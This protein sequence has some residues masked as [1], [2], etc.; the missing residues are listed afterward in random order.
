MLRRIPLRL[1]RKLVLRTPRLPVAERQCRDESQRA[2]DNGKQH[3]A[4]H[5]VIALQMQWDNAGALRRDPMKIFIV[6][7]FVAIMGALGTA[8]LFLMKDRGHGT[9]T[10]NALRL[11]VGL[12]IALLLLIW[13]SWYMG[14]ISPRSY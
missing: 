8:L 3:T 10:L 13:F 2:D 5:H 4:A 11:R 1:Q 6:V 12:S 7:A 9:R 14:W